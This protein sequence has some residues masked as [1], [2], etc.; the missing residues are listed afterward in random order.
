MSIPAQGVFFPKQVWA[1]SLSHLHDCG[2]AIIGSDVLD[3]KHLMFSVVLRPQSLWLSH[4]GKPKSRILGSD[5]KAEQATLL[6]LL[7]ER[8]SVLGLVASIAGRLLQ[9]QTDWHSYPHVATNVSPG[10]SFPSPYFPNLQVEVTVAS[11]MCGHQDQSHVSECLAQPA[12]VWCGTSHVLLPCSFFPS[13]PRYF[14]KIL[15]A[16]FW[17]DRIVL[18]SLDF[19]VP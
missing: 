11:G 6:S 10:F 18:C 16:I 1:C 17:A 14:T 2:T 15:K 13:Q 12:P 5:W 8:M 7:G 4:R 3:T 19:V 9:A